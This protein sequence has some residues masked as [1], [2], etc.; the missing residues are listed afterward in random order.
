MTGS[1]KGFTLLEVLVALAI[2][3][4]ALT[5]LVVVY[6]SH[7]SVVIRDREETTALLLARTRLDDPNFLSASVNEGNFGPDYPN[8]TW[9]RQ[10]T[11]SDYPGLIRYR[12]TVAWHQGS[13]KLTLV[14]Y[15]GQ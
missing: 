1:A 2:M 15:A 7:L 8:I 11:P 12:L 13:R 6:N 3:A 14:T 9:Q 4:G 5:S 10:A